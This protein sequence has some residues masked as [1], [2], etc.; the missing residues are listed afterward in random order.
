VPEACTFGWTYEANSAYGVLGCV[1]G[2]RRKAKIRFP[3]RINAAREALATGRPAR[4]RK[5]LLDLLPETLL[6]FG[7][8][9]WRRAWR[10]PRIQML[11]IAVIPDQTRRLSLSMPQFFH[12]MDKFAVAVRVS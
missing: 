5:P 12:P 1:R 10:L 8:C 3:G 4:S 11:R 6:A 2:R 9:C 7:S